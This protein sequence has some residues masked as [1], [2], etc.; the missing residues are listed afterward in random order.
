MGPPSYKAKN[1]FFDFFF[2]FRSEFI[3]EPQTIIE[4]KQDPLAGP[5]TTTIMFWK[6]KHFLKIGFLNF[7]KHFLC[8]PHRYI[9]ANAMKNI[10]TMI[11]LP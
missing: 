10:K 7:F 8:P 1:S 3:S 5:E 11:P 2:D 4:T 9:T 6:F